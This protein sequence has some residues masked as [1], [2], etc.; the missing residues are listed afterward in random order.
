MI[1][2]LAVVER[3]EGQ[4]VYVR[5]SVKTTC[6]GCAQNQHCGTGIVAKNMTPRSELLAIK[7]EQD[8]AIGDT[9]KIGLPETSVLKASTLVYLLP[10]FSM[11]VSSVSGSLILPAMGFEHELWVLLLTIVTTA[12]TYI[13]IKRYLLTGD[14]VEFTPVLL[15]V[16]SDNSNK[17]TCF[18]NINPS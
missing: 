3:L 17:T 18:S 5:T 16:E 10:L 7:V 9:V 8:V 4:H 13:S 15:S 1:E 11:L 6:H 2:Q 12:V 14:E